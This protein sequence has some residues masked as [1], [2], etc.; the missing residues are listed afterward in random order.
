[1]INSSFSLQPVLSIGQLLA[2]WAVIGL[3]GWR[4]WL[5][6]RDTVKYTVEL[7][8]I[9]CSRCQFFTKNHRLKCTIHPKVAMSEAAIGCPD[10]CRSDT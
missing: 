5:I 4:V 10:F 3:V 7:H 8:T 1:M 2:P 6:L 9:P